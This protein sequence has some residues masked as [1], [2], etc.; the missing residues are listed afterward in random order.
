MDG[1]VDSGAFDGSEGS[2]VGDSLDVKEAGVVPVVPPA[3]PSPVFAFFSAGVTIGAAE[4]V[5]AALLL[6]R[7]SAS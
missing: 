1:G 4:G 5:G 6:V 3:S 7:D 2:G